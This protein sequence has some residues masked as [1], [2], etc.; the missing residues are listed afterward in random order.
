[1]SV[2]IPQFQG[3]TFEGIRN[4]L[5]TMNDNIEALKEKFNDFQKNITDQIKTRPTM[6]EIING[7]SVN[8]NSFGGFSIK[9]ETV[10][11]VLT[12]F[13][14]IMEENLEKASLASEKQEIHMSKMIDT[15][16]TSIRLS[17]QKYKKALFH[18]KT[19]LKYV[20]IHLLRVFKTKKLSRIFEK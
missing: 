14:S 10:N 17:H 16:N 20:H 19:N 15:V 3:I 6:T 13:A 4:I 12:S 5:V 8:T 1:M 11:N 2:S 18:S 7:L 9:I